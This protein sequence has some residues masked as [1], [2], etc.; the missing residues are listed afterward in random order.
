V[1][2]VN[3]SGLRLVG[4][5]KRF[6]ATHAVDG[7]SL[8]VNAGEVHGVVGENGAGKSTLLKIASGILP[9]G[10]GEVW[11]GKEEPVPY[12]ARR[13]YQLGV[14][15]VQ[16]HFALFGHLTALENMILGAE[17]THT[18]GRLD[19][20]RARQRA[21]RVLED[22]DIHLALDERVSSFSV[23]EKQ[24]VEI[25]RTL[26]RDAHVIILDE[27]TAVLTP[28]ESTALFATLRRLAKGGRAIVVVT[29]KLDEVDAHA[30]VVTVMRR[31]QSL[32]TRP[33]IKGSEV[34]R[35]AGELL[36]GVTNQTEVRETRALGEVKL[37]VSGLAAGRLAGV[38]FEVRAGEIV[39]VA[40]VLGNGQTELIEVLGGLRTAVRG[41]VEAS[42]IEVVHEDRHEAGM[43]LDATV[44]DN[45][46]LGELARFSRFGVLDRGALAEVAESRILA[47]G[48]VPPD[49]SLL[50][51]AL[52][53][54]NQQKVVIARALSRTPSVLVIAHP[55]RG[56]DL[57][58]ARAIHQHILDAARSGTAI[59]VV[60][61][62]LAELRALSTRILVIARGRLV[63]TLP[64][65]AD[66]DT[67]G[68]AMLGGVAAA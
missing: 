35:L 44:R 32:G 46:V 19:L 52:S 3:A 33:V 60:S 29:H 24:R 5:H 39:G 20:A 56:V 66:D 58:A 40:G 21:S 12:D 7:A 6:G 51:R 59:L 4:I 23:A 28:G 11:V 31:G 1:A 27:P 36:G 26:Y 64:P 61:A 2:P 48:V 13:A 65:D 37:K 38:S 10:S 62:D 53:G 50:A 63:A 8:E 45:V 14:A 30:D 55:T 43:I 47:F 67:I 49:T 25:A 57:G 15:M 68:A 17:P 18:G 16:Q 9:K 41:S 34:A 22:L 54:G 42:R